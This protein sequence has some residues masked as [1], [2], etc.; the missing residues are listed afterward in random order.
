MREWHAT[1][2]CPLDRPVGECEGHSLNQTP[3]VYNGVQYWSCRDGQARA[4][5]PGEEPKMQPPN[6]GFSSFAA[7]GIA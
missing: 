1:L 7:L 4:L 6:Y 2:P 5:E 3:T